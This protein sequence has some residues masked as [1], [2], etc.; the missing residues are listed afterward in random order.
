MI[1]RDAPKPHQHAV[2]RKEEFQRERTN[3]EITHRIRAREKMLRKLEGKGDGKPRTAG[4][5]P[6]T[7][8]PVLL[9]YFAADT[10]GHGDS[11]LASGSNPVAAAA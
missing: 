1:I 9:A 10:H 8:Y 7:G 3:L 6:E 11:G 5:S 4:V 2:N